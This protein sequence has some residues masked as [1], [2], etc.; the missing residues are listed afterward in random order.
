MDRPC[1]LLDR[2]RQLQQRVLDVSS[3][4]RILGQSIPA[5]RSTAHR[6]REEGH[7][8][9]PPK[10]ATLLHS[11]PTHESIKTRT[12]PRHAKRGKTYVDRSARHVSRVILC[13]SRRTWNSHPAC[14]D[15]RTGQ[16]VHGFRN[17]TSQGMH[18]SYVH[19]QRDGVSLQSQTSRQLRGAK[20]GPHCAA[21]ALYVGGMYLAFGFS[22]VVI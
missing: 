6:R 11:S 8:N 21:L 9:I 4:T 22:R 14:L 1:R 10:L 16:S 20:K 12:C 18:T 15:R 17:L 2:T 13:P 19:Q 3:H 5:S 7:W